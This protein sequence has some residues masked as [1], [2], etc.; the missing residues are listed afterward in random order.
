[1]NIEHS[2]CL[3]WFSRKGESQKQDG[4]ML[5]SSQ[6]GCGAFSA[7]GDPAMAFGPSYMRMGTAHPGIGS[8][9]AGQWRLHHARR[10]ARGF[11]PRAN[12]QRRMPSRSINPL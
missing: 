2:D 1:M 6:R 11:L 3:S 9:A 8:F 4:E 10:R 5:S 12:G 7:S